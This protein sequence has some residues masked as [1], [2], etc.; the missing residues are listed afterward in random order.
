MTLS[1]AVLALA[2]L[3]APPPAEVDAAVKKGG[4]FLLKKYEKGLD[5]SL[6]GWNLE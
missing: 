4:E 2:A 5:P 3:Q 1:M 6:M